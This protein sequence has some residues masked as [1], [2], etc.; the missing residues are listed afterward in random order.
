M[1][2]AT[3]KAVRDAL[4]GMAKN[5]DGLKILKDTA[6]LIKA[7][8]PYG[9]VPETDASYENQREVYRLIWKKEGR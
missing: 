2:K 9:F 3:A 4:T 5:P 8:A 6:D 7:G 1:P